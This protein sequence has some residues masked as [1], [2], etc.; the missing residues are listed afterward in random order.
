MKIAREEVTFKVGDRRL[1][2]KQYTMVMEILKE[3]GIN[4]VAEAE[5]IVNQL[6]E[7]FTQEAVYYVIENIPHKGLTAYIASCNNFLQKNGLITEKLKLARTETGDFTISYRNAI[8]S[9]LTE[10]K[11]ELLHDILDNLI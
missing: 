8:M 1:T 2:E 7:N 9:V 5:D 3:N 11:K 10:D 6:P 4:T